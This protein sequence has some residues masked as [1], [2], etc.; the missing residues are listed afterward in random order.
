MFSKTPT[1]KASKGS[2]QIV[3]SHD[4]LQLRFRFGGKRHYLSI[5]LPDT[6]VNRKLAEA[7]ARQIELDLL[8]GNFDETLTKYKPQSVLSTF[9]P[10]I[11][12]KAAITLLELWAKY[13]DYKAPNASPKTINGTYEP[14]SAHL[15]K[16]ST[17]GLE[18]ALKFR[19]ELLQATTQSQARRTLM[20]LSAACRWGSKHGLIASNPL[21]GMYKELEAT[22]PVPPVSFTVEERNRIIEAFE[23]DTRPG[24]NYRHYAPFVKF[25]FWTGCRPCEAVG[26]RWGSIAPSCGRIH[27]HES[28]VEVSGKLVR[29]EETKTGVK[30]WFSCTPKLQALLQA[31]RPENPA[32]NALV[33][34]SPKG[35]AI[36]ESNFSDRA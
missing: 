19:M 31:I 15:K 27:F 6:P 2:V 3:T 13:V 22:S 8:S 21:D 1:G 5:G 28:I 24:M 35:G 10:D 30:R 12:P 9:T 20:Q 33:F 7:K 29:R 16:C 18:D 36:G 26:L 34:P 4:R 11:T 14:V 17:D 25:L 23:N 32:P